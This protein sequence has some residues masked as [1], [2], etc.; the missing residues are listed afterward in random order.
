MRLAK[1][2]NKLTISGYKKQDV[3]IAYQNSMIND[4]IED[5]IRWLVELHSTGMES[6]IWQSLY[7]LITKYVHI[8]NP[9]LYVYFKKRYQEYEVILNKYPPKLQHI[10]SRNNQEI[11]NMLSELTSIC[12]LTKKNNIFLPNSYP[13]LG[14][15]FL[16]R[17]ELSKRMLS[18]DL[19]NITDYCHLSTT[20][21]MKLG[22]NEI[23]TNISGNG[24]GT[25][26]NCLYWYL[27]LEK[28]EIIRRKDINEPIE[29]INELWT[30]IIWK[31][32]NDHKSLLDDNNKIFLKKLYDDYMDNFKPTSINKKKYLIFM[33]F[34]TFKKKINWNI[35]LYQ[36]EYI[37]LQVLGNINR[38]YEKIKNHNES[39]LNQE[40]KNTLYNN[41]NKIFYKKHEQTIVPNKR[42]ER[43]G[44]TTLNSETN[45][46]IFTKYPEY[47][48]ISKNTIP[49]LEPVKNNKHTLVQYPKKV[50]FVDTSKTDRYNNIYERYSKKSDY[51]NDEDDDY[52]S[53][54][55]IEDDIERNIPIRDKRGNKINEYKQTNRKEENRKSRNKRD[56]YDDYDDDDENE[57]ELIA[58]RVTNEDIINAKEERMLMKIDAFKQLIIKREPKDTIGYNEKI[59]NSPYNEL[60]NIDIVKKRKNEM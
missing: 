46:I 34:Y 27:W 50:E 18:R 6:N 35:Q 49:K 20:N 8:N 14:K 48:Q 42:P 43:I 16:Q 37:L 28:I 17:E 59:N 44:D 41:F 9:K 26:E 32:L 58:K 1:D 24:K 13:K 33:A 39:N 56:D 53:I 30:I 19:Y 10:Y 7:L 15:N 36:Q 40:N 45:D 55:T 5:A 57:E 54:D 38:M 22:L 60:K 4:K 52:C 47:H 21:E 31:I 3:V 2:F 51:E 29:N 23:L 12:C 25:F 11:R